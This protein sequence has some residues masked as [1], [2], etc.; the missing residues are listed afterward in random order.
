MN[1]LFGEAKARLQLWKRKSGDPEDIIDL[2]VLGAN[3]DRFEPSNRIKQIRRQIDMRIKQFKP[4]LTMICAKVL[5]FEG[6]LEEARILA[7][8]YEADADS[9]TWNL[10]FIE[11][12]RQRTFMARGLLQQVDEAQ[13]ALLV[14]ERWN[15]N[16]KLRELATRLRKCF[17]YVDRNGAVFLAAAPWADAT[18]L[19][20]QPFRE[21]HKRDSRLAETLALFHGVAEFAR[22]Q[23]LE[24]AEAMPRWLSETRQKLSVSSR[25]H[26]QGK[27]I[28]SFPVSVLPQRA[29][30]LAAAA[31]V[32][33]EGNILKPR[34]GLQRACGR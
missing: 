29:P 13:L 34:I 2:A 33:A 23:E 18:L 27:Q 14:A 16:S 22:Q 17:D 26:K 12:D 3:L 28:L 30:A 32:V 7:L 4:D 9:D 20:Y 21:L 31:A 24:R 19:S 25:S 11:R 10:D 6:W 15:T 5:D 8:S 1:Q